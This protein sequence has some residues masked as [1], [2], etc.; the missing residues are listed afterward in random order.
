MGQA[1]FR[2]THTTHT[3]ACTHTHIRTHT[4]LLEP[5]RQMEVHDA[6]VSL[7]QSHNPEQNS[8]LRNVLVVELY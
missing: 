7:W 3:H 1:I 6:A 4:P 5:S 8:I 2:D